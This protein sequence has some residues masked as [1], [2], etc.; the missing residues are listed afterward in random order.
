M[1]FLQTLPVHIMAI[2]DM[3]GHPHHSDHSSRASGFVQADHDCPSL[4]LLALGYCVLIAVYPLLPA[5]AFTSPCSWWRTETIHTQWQRT[6]KLSA[7]KAA[8]I[9][10][11]LAYCNAKV[12]HTVLVNREGNDTLKGGGFFPLP[13]PQF[14]IFISS[15]DL[16]FTF[17]IRHQ[18]L[19]WM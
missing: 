10:F 16:V 11:S 13:P 2:T 17:S 14:W 7:F 1:V 6:E 15:N 5:T 19:T 8:F 18:Q 3:R 12:K 9:P 4:L